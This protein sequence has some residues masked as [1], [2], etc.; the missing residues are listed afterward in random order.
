[1]SVRQ[2]SS[3]IHS[4][5]CQAYKSHAITRIYSQAHEINVS[6]ISTKTRN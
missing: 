6:V 4:K 1:M 2:T 3:I 5:R